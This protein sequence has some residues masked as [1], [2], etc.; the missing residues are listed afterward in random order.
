MPLVYFRTTRPYDITSFQQIPGMVGHNEEH[1][2]TYPRFIRG[3]TGE[4]LF[5]Y[6]DGR[7][8]NGDQYF[9]L[10]NPR[11]ATWNRLIESPLFAGGGQMN[12]YFTGPEQDKAGVFHVCWVWRE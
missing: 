10:W 1:R 2:C 6:R 4:L 3:A 12:A 5:T 9:N 8:G 11:T 7:S